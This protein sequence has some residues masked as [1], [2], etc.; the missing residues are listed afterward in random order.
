MSS[1]RATVHDAPADNL[2]DATTDADLLGVQRDLRDRLVA[3]GRLIPTGL[4]GLYGRDEVFETIVAA[5][6]AKAVGLGADEGATA[7]EYPPVIPA[8]DFATIGYLRNF[9]QL[10]G[11]VFSFRGDDAQ[12]GAMAREIDAG[13]DPHHHLAPAP[14]TLTPACCYPVYPSARGRLGDEGRSFLISQYC[15]R[16]EPSVDPMRMVAFR[17]REYVRIGHPGQIAAFRARWSERATGYFADLQLTVSEDFANDAFFGR[18]GR[19][20]KRNQRDQELKTEFGVPVHSRKH[21]TACASIND[22]QD[23]FGDIFGITTPDGQV[24][25]S[26]C[27]GFG[28][29]RITVALMARHGFDP[30]EWPADVR[31]QLWP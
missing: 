15:F 8:A 17:Q 7:V 16:N 30:A 25:H 5:V 6:D 12:F 29:E 23:H 24:A 19:L 18:A 13:D 21:V 10:S 4:D 3:A 14:V 1:D 9:P 31:E 20:M 2:G 27:I 28:L 11:V 26:S 22:H